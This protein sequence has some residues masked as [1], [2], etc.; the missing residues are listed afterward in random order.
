MRFLRPLAALGAV[1]SVAVGIAACGG[2]PSDSVATVEGN[3]IKNAT[4]NHW[5]AV[6][7]TANAS[8]T[9]GAPVIPTPP[10]F[11]ACISHL[12]ATSAKTK[13]AKPPTHAQLKSECE[14]QYQSLKKEVV[15]YLISSEWVLGEAKNLGIKLSDSEVHKEF[16]KIRSEQFPTS[17]EFEKF[18]KTS[19][20]T[21]SDL[22]LRVKLN[23]LSQKI[24]HKVLV[25]N[26]HVTNAEI[27][28]YYRENKT[29][30][31]SP[32][33]RS[34]ALVL[35]KAEAAAK[36]AKKEVEEGKSW[37]E[38]AKKRSIDP[39]SKAKGGMLKE[40]V[41]GQE[42]KQLSEALF[43]APLHTLSGPVKTPFGYYI[44]E[45]KSIKPATSKP[46]SSVHKRIKEQLSVTKDQKALAAFVKEFKKRWKEQTECREG[47]VVP[48]CKEYAAPKE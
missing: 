10:S 17:A 30:F 25:E 48:N 22:L 1:L 2:V 33:T 40:V 44:Y 47:Y 11:S 21:V 5:L 12:A 32:E 42:T 29:T 18:L 24:Q 38:V 35:T 45:V 6:A 43:A 28:K 41:K 26:E 3:S 46:L 13:K 8:E 16:M 31:G 37:A 15:N 7:A 36:E 20:Q 14:T 34:V 27:E 9:G 4:F 23:M 39:V 19:G